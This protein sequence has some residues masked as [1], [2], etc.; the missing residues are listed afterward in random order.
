MDDSY[1]KQLFLLY[2]LNNGLDVAEEHQYEEAKIEETA[3]VVPR[4]S[5]ALLTPSLRDKE[6]MSDMDNKHNNPTFH[7]DEV[8]K[9]TDVLRDSTNQTGSRIN[10]SMSAE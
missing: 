9:F 8:R 4:E 1:V 6:N 7:T 10:F 2:K 3:I 5:K